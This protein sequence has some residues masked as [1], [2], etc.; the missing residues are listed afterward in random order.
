MLRIGNTYATVFRPEV[1]EKMVVASLSTSEKMPDGSYRNSNWGNTIFVG[2]AVDAAKQLKDKD[3]IQIIRGGARIEP[4]EDKKGV[5]R[6]PSKLVIFEFQIA[7]K[8]TGSSSSDD[9]DMAF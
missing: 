2:K 1:K 7:S 5:M 9:E 3:R 4:Y 8:P 6:Y